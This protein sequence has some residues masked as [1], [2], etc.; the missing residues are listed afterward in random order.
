M[1][2]RDVITNLQSKAAALSGM[3]EAPTDPPESINQFPFA[4][5]YVQNGSWTPESAG[6]SH[7]LISLVTEI[8]IARNVLPLDIQKAL[9]FFEP[10]LRAILNDLSLGSTVDTIGLIEFSFGGMTYG[11]SGGIPVQTIG[12]KFTISDVKIT[13]LG[14]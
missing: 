11:E 7:A 5:T 13:I 12:W 14:S 8:H 9:P 2:L 10:F 4:L 1:A 3:K 6:F